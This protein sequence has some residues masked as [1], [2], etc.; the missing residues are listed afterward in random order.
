[1]REHRWAAEIIARDRHLR[2]PAWDTFS[3]SEM[4]DD[5]RKAAIADAQQDLDALHNEGY[6]LVKGYPP[7]PE[8]ATDEEVLDAFFDLADPGDQS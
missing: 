3:W 1:M 4:S 2:R 6:V 7:A 8:P 5:Y